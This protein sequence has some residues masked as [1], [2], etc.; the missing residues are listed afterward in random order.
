[1]LSDKLMNRTLL[2]GA[3]LGVAAATAGGVFAGEHL[4]AAIKRR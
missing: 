2:R 1:M 3:P 4:E